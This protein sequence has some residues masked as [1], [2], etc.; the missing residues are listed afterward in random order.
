M[1]VSTM[2]GA[3]TLATLSVLVFAQ[4]NVEAA[5]HYKVALVALERN[6]LDIALE[7]LSVCARLAPDNA[8]VH[9]NLAVVQSKKEGQSA[10]ALASLQRAMNLGLPPEKKDAAETLLATLTYDLK[11]KTARNDASPSA[12]VGDS[13]PSEPRPLREPGVPTSPP[14]KD[15][16]PQLIGTW[17]YDGTRPAGFGNVHIV[18]ALSIRPATKEPICDLIYREEIINGGN[19]KPYDT[20]EFKGTMPLSYRD[21]YIYGEAVGQ[22]SHRNINIKLK[23]EWS[24]A[25]LI[26]DQIRIENGNLLLAFKLSIVAGRDRRTITSSTVSG[27]RR[28]PLSK[29]K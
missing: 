24:R 11:A 5:R 13:L 27:L 29:V 7:E 4:E 22:G 14:L 17:R 6:D 16:L 19:G 25:S 23:P 20:H 1:N 12:A 18:M 10:E 21:A 26:L 2:I 8:L 3:F 15:V 9:F 28:F